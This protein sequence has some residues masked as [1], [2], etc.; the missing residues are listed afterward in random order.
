MLLQ[1][2]CILWK[3]I[4][5]TEGLKHFQPILGCHSL[6]LL[7]AG[8][9]CASN[10]RAS[11]QLRS[12]GVKQCVCAVKCWVW[13]WAAFPAGRRRQCRTDSWKTCFQK[14][15]GRNTLKC[16][17]Q[18]C[19]EALQNP[20]CWLAAGEV[21]KG[22]SVL[23]SLR[24]PALVCLQRSD[25]PYAL[26]LVPTREVG[27]F[28]FLSL[29]E[30]WFLGDVDVGPPQKVNSKVRKHCPVLLLRSCPHRVLSVL[31]SAD[32]SKKEGVSKFSSCSWKSLWRL[33]NLSGSVHTSCLAH[34]GE[35]V[36]PINSALQMCRFIQ[37]FHF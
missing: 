17:V 24:G 15:W 8:C 26:V 33:Q 28:S 20:L 12:T 23:P 34:T 29:F 32:Q 7:P 18:T 13:L 30:H 25:G 22:C 36:K 35:W 37:T 27:G 21:W 6:Q 11:L 31:F 9:C 3:E 1:I 4:T 19:T 14:L 10:R 16:C 2:L 5:L